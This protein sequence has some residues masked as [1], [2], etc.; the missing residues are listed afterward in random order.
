MRFKESVKWSKV[1]CFVWD[2]VSPSY[3]NDSRKYHNL[4][5]IE[6]M[7]AAA[8]DLGFEH[9]YALDYAVMFHDVIY[10]NKGDNEF[11]SAMYAANLMNECA[12]A[13]DVIGETFNHIM[14][15]KCHSFKGDNRIVI[16]DM[17]GFTDEAV[18]KAN[19][20]AVIEELHIS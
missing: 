20:M 12:I 11:R 5:H 15:T 16:L 8:H 17:Y 4:K 19:T 14:K 6:S 3:N 10:D 13:G 9:D 7:Y 1:S 18:A 2:E